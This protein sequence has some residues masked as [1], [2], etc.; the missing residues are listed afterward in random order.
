MPLGLFVL[1]AV[2][3]VQFS[4]V[5]MLKL[6]TD[7]PPGVYLTSASRPRLPTRITLFTLPMARRY[8]S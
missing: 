2:L 4:V 6:A 8:L 7:C 3:D 1:L 5:A